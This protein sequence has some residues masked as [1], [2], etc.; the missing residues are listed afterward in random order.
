VYHSRQKT[1]THHLLPKEGGFYQ[2]GVFF[3]RHCPYDEDSDNIHR[4]EEDL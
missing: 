2:R 3:F 1:K 4:P